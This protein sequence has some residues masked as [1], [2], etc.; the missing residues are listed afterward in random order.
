MGSSWDIAYQSWITYKNLHI[1]L[2]ESKPPIVA[3]MLYIFK[4]FRKLLCQQNVWVLVMVT[5]CSKRYE[6]MYLSVCNLHL[7]GV[8]I[9]VRRIGM[10]S[11]H[12]SFMQL[13]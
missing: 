4:F 2:C 5:M 1:F 13:M 3:R 6:I 11:N 9:V 12:T 8:S 7:T 10:D